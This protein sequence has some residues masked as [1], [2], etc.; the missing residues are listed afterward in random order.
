MGLS[1]HKL[2]N[3]NHYNEKT[4]FQGVHAKS[5]VNRGN[6]DVRR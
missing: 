1:K 2:I 6:V 5:G 3:L 4:F